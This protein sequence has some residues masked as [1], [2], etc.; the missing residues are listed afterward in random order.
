MVSV[1]CDGVGKTTARDDDD[2]RYDEECERSDYSHQRSPPQ[3]RS[4]RPP[5]GEQC[6]VGR[7]CARDDRRAGRRCRS[8]DAHAS[9]AGCRRPDADRLG[10]PRAATLFR[11]NPDAPKI[12]GVIYRRKWWRCFS[13]GR[14]VRAFRTCRRHGWRSIPGSLRSRWVAD[15]QRARRSARPKWRQRRTAVRQRRQGR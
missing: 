3:C 15:R 7:R 6:G 10:H 14:A 11:S 5:G 8:F 9:S 13:V 4:A 12:S 1:P 2:G